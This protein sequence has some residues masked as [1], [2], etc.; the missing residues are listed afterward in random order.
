MSKPE[1]KQFAELTDS[2][3]DRHPVWI[4]CHTADYDEPWYEDTDEETFRPRTG[5][6]PA[7]PSEGMLL[8]RATFSL[9]DG[10]TFNGF[11]TPS[12]EEQDLG[13]QQPQM[14]VG[15]RRFGFWGGMFGLP[16]Q[17]RQ[18]FYAAVARSTPDVFPLRFNADPNLATGATSGVVEGF[19][20][21][22]KRVEIER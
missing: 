15:G 18:E 20:K 19:Y 8:V 11:V 16:A 17:E 3:F 12:F 14:F 9:R 22:D 1:L 5:A 21:R 10:T 6:L 7:A 4:A 2:D 13:T